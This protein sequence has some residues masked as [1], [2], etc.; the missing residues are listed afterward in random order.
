MA[1]LE[2]ILFDGLLNLVVLILKIGLTDN[3]R[4]ELRLG[5]EIVTPKFLAQTLEVAL[6]T[7]EFGLRG[8]GL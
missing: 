3:P 1:P 7:F 2:S 5:M 4:V 8:N 6:K